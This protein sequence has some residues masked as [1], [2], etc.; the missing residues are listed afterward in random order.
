MRKFV[1]IRQAD[2]EHR[3]FKAFGRLWPTSDFIGRVLPGD[4]GKRVYL[5]GHILQVENEEQRARRELRQL[6][7][8]LALLSVKRRDKY[9]FGIFHSVPGQQG[10]EETGH[11]P[12]E[13]EG[14]A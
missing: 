10:A 8:N 13:K 4:V 5:V 1:T 12:L 14:Q 9:L 3:L 6:H 2:V 7:Y 11:T